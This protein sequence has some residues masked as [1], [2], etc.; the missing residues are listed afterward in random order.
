MGYDFSNAFGHLK[1]DKVMA[2]LIKKF[3]HKITFDD[4]YDSNYS[5]AIANLIIEQ[6]VSF[7]AAN[8]IKKRFNKLI[9]NISNQELLDLDLNKLKL[10]GI[11]SRKCEYIKNV[12]A[13]FKSSNFD[14]EIHNNKEIIDELTKIKGIGSWTAKMFLMFVLFREN[15]FSSKDLAI[16][17]SIKQNYKFKEVDGIILDKLTT[18]WSPYNTIASLLLWKSIEEKIFYL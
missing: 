8:A 6:Q 5:K 4:R 12:Y 9:K 15:V 10:I 17:N 13:Y 14:F 11:S 16:I 1:S 3:G 18:K 7:N 2:F